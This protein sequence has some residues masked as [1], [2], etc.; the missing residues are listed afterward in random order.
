V[1][2]SLRKID[3]VAQAPDGR[4]HLVQTDHRSPAEIE[5]EPEL[6]TLFALARILLPQ[7]S[8]HARG[9]AEG[10]AVV[11]YVALGGVHP[12]IACVVASTGAE[13]EVD[14]AGSGGV[15]L[16]H[17]ATSAP[18][19]L[20]DVAFAGLG[21]R[22]LERHGLTATEEGLASLERRIGSHGGAPTE[23]EVGYWTMVAELAAVTGEVIRATIGGRWIDDEH[24]YADIPFLFR[25]GDEGLSVNAVGKAVKFLAHGDSES[26]R[27]LLR[28]LEDRATPAGPL[29]VGL[30]PSSWGAKDEMVCEP[31]V[32][33]G[34]ATG[35]D[36]PL[37]VYGHDHPNTFAMFKR[38]DSMRDLSAMRTE[39]LANLVSVE[40][41]VEKVVLEALTF[42]IG[43]GNYFAAEK[44]L[45]V[46]FM[47]QMHA[48]IGELLAVAVPEKGRLFMANAVADADEIAGFLALARGVFERNEGGRQLSPT[49]FLVSEGKI[50]GVAQPQGSTTVEEVD[51]LSGKKKSKRLL[52]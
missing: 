35:A 8:L 32:D 46:P 42:W 19:D 9:D 45:D 21:R 13:L 29:L 48:H 33:L 43:H 4:R 44:V 11:R 20:A 27:H 40:I 34:H 24:A 10:A 30:K 5:E 47:Q 50:V 39:A 2:S 38:G 16:A 25:A 23:D 22:V 7:R 6:S 12:V 15:D 52:N 41:E 28:A 1:Y 26:P 17:V 51:P 14:G 36:V 49:V 18:A 31:M 3:F 37:I